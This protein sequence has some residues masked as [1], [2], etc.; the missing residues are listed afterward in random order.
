MNDFKGDSR[1]PKY[2]RLVTGLL[3]LHFGML[4]ICNMPRHI[5]NEQHAKM[6]QQ[7]TRHQAPIFRRP[8]IALKI[9]HSAP[10]QTPDHHTL[11]PKKT[12]SHSL[13]L[14]SPR[15]SP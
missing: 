6:K 8:R 12:Q 7:Q 5:A 2:R 14:P 1:A 3:L 11:N 9:I 4:F 13:T 15:P 10:P